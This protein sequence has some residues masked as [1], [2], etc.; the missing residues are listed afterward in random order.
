M[1][2]SLDAVTHRL[3]IDQ[4]RTQIQPQMPTSVKLQ[5]TA[6]TLVL[7]L[8]QLPSQRHLNRVAITYLQKRAAIARNGCIARMRK[9]GQRRSMKC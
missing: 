3:F 1:S 5:Q 9:F 7:F 8:L 6:S 4:S 2:L